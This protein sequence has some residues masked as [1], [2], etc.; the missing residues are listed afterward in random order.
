MVEEFCELEELE[1]VCGDR[2]G[3][4]IDMCSLLCDRLWWLWLGFTSWLVVASQTFHKRPKKRWSGMSGFV[5]LLRRITRSSE[6]IIY[7]GCWGC[8]TFLSHFGE[9][10]CRSKLFP[11]HVS[12][13]RVHALLLLMMRAGFS[14]FEHLLP[15]KTVG[16][17]FVRWDEGC[18]NTQHTTFQPP[19]KTHELS[20]HSTQA[21]HVLWLHV[22]NSSSQQPTAPAP[23]TAASSQHQHQQ[24][25]HIEQSLQRPI[26]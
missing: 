24:H 8:D 16:V 26:S 5:V 6:L 19:V 9:I 15:N 17:W 22:A 21:H 20:R 18:P 4:S 12:H 13:T 25:Y 2:G 1:A 11:R 14:Q 10:L 7:G 23:A 3:E